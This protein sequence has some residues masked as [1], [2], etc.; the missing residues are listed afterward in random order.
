MK[1]GLEYIFI[2]VTFINELNIRQNLLLKNVMGIKFHSRFKPLLNALGVKSIYQLYFK[3]KTFGLKQVYKNVLSY[4]IHEYLLDSYANEQAP[5]Q[6][7]LSQLDKVSTFARTDISE[8]LSESMITSIDAKFTC[9]DIE[10][11]ECIS[12]VLNN[13]N[14]F[15][16][17]F[18][19]NLLNN[20]LY[21][22]F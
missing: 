3:H 22:E 21:V 11:R 13:Y 6:S 18:Y 15:Y 19:I 7:F 2:N 8:L 20:F 10:L 16:S 9:N 17:H 1:F 12:A 5:K 14:I 4:E